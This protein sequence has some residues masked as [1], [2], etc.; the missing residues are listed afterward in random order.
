MNSPDDTSDDE[1]KRAK[2]APK[3]M[4]APPPKS[5]GPQGKAN[6]AQNNKG[7]KVQPSHQKAQRHKGR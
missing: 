6:R 4:P 3:K 1:I 2:A 7:N 5:Y